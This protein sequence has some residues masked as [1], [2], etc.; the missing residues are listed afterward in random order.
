MHEAA[1]LLQG[2]RIFALKTSEGAVPPVFS[3]G[4]HVCLL[5]HYYCAAQ[6]LHSMDRCMG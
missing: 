6:V 3:W 1:Q 2:K 5:M 4:E